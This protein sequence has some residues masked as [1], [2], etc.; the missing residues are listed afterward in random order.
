MDRSDA[1]TQTFYGYQ[2]QV[3]KH[4][5][6]YIPLMGLAPFMYTSDHANGL[7]YVSSRATLNE[8]FTDKYNGVFLRTP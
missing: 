8:T 7:Q 3:E 1:F 5:V 6:K 2:F 4:T